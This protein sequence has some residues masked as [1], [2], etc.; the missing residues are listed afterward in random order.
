MIW[1]I[2]DSGQLPFSFVLGDGAFGHDVEFVNGLPKGV[3]YYLTVHSDDKFF[4][5]LPE[6]SIPVWSGKGRPPKNQ[7]ASEKPM[8]ARLLVEESE[9]PW[10]EV[11]FGLGSKGFVVGHEKLLQVWESRDGLPGDLVWLHARRLSDG[12]VKYSISNAPVDTPAEKFSELA[13]RRWN[14]EQCFEECKTDLG[15]DHYEGRSWVGWRRHLLI[16]FVVHLFLQLMRI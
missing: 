9:T 12:S 5:T 8:E 14:I 3:N 10:R 2:H 15:M 13:L 16:V 4:K 7:R 1:S 6:V 11:T